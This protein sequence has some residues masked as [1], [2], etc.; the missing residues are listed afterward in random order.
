M[1]ITKPT[2]KKRKP[3]GKRQ[4]TYYWDWK[5]RLNA[6]QYIE[7]LC[8][9]LESPLDSMYQMDGNMMIS[10]YHELISGLHHIRNRNEKPNRG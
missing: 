10:D 8:G 3:Y 6:E 4:K 2:S 9:V 5:T 1:T 7:K